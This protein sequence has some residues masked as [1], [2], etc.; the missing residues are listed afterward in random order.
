[1]TEFIEKYYYFASGSINTERAVADTLVHFFNYVLIQVHRKNN[2]FDKVNGL[3][4]LEF[5]HLESYLTYCGEINNS[6]KTVERKE[7][8]LV[9]FYFFMGYEKKVLN[10]IPDITFQNIERT[11][12][13]RKKNKLK[14]NLYYKKPDKNGY[15]RTMIM[16]K[17]FLTQQRNDILDKNQA[18]LLFIREFLLLA[19]KEV[20]DIAFAICLQIYGGLRSAECMNL[21]IGSLEPQNMSKYGEKGLV[22][23]IRDRQELLFNHDSS[24]HN[25]Q[26]KK[27]RDQAILIDPLVPYL[28]Q[29]HMKWLNIKKK[30][31]KN[32]SN[33][34]HFALFINSKGEAMRTYTYRERFNKLKYIYLGTLK[35]TNGRYEDYREF[36]NSKWSTHI[37]RGVFT[38]LCLDSGFNAT[39]TSI[40]RGDSSPEA[41]HAYSD[42]LTASQ[43]IHQAIEIISDISVSDF[44]DIMSE[45]LIDEWKKVE[46]NEF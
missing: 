40:M 24:T 12:W 10:K 25:D 36:R 46:S 2:D 41:M 11:E 35:N 27:Q 43:K 22:V 15:D 31:L 8:Y 42:I 1:M 13:K 30:S 23:E 39:Q 6:R 32:R 34:N 9:K 18:R 7:I 45:D 5:K 4:D 17:D 14:A 21:T 44:K 29:K 20:P 3:K 37:C 28:Y 33:I 38:N 19:S 16:K 26:V